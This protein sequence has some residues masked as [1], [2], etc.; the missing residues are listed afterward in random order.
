VGRHQPQACRKIAE[1]LHRSDVELVGHAKPGV[2][3]VKNDN[4]C[5]RPPSRARARHG[6]M[7]VSSV[8]V[9]RPCNTQAHPS[10]NPTRVA[11]GAKTRANGSCR[12]K[13]MANHRCRM[14]GGLS[15]GPKTIGGRARIAEAQRR[16]WASWRRN[17]AADQT[18]RGTE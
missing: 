15:S 17:M 10:A 11:C 4:Y 18:G 2:R 1:A 16:R 14:H 9:E 5:G 6:V 3:L 8:R 12:A 13:A 7:G